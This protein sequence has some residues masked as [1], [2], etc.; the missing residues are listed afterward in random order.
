MRLENTISDLSSPIASFFSLSMSS[1]HHQR[2]SIKSE[3]TAVHVYSSV[4]SSSKVSGMLLLYMTD[5]CALTIRY[6]IG[7]I[8]M[9]VT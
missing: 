6:I 5:A 7:F 2:V 4:S 9:H 8:D 3:A 1:F